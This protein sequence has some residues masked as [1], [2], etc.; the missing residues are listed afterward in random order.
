[1]IIAKLII[2]DVDYGPHPFL[3]QIRHLRTHKPVEGAFLGEIGP[4]MGLESLDSG[5]SRYEFVTIPKISLLNRFWDITNEGK[6]QKKFEPIT[7]LSIV[8]ASARVNTIKAI[9]AQLASALTISLR[10]S[11]IRKQFSSPKIPSQELPIIDYQIQQHKLFPVLSRLFCLIFN[12][13]KLED[14]Q[15]ECLRRIENDDESL[16]IEFVNMS[17]LYKMMITNRCINDIEMCRRA[18]GGHGYMKLSGFST[19]YANSLPTATYAGDNAVISIEVMKYIYRHKPKHMWGDFIESKSY[20]GDSKWFQI[21][22]RHHL[23]RIEENYQ[24]LINK[25]ISDTEI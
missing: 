22:T 18:C 20:K 4:K 8:H 25:K 15:K 21:I 17:S 14:L 11:S 16:V 23:L 5:Y 24:K 6:Y 9:W 2:D 1:M 12:N 10:Y 3:M 7:M 13:R 19:L